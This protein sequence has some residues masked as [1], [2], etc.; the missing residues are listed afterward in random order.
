MLAMIAGLHSPR[1]KP[2][3]NAIDQV[4]APTRSVLDT[5][6]PVQHLSRPA[7]LNTLADRPKTERASGEGVRQPVRFGGMSFHLALLSPTGVHQLDRPSDL[8]CKENTRQHAVD[9]ALLSCK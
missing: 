9:D 1:R 7:R 2:Q 5:A 6:A 8:S 3:V 4:S